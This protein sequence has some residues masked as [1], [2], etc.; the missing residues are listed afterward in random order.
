[1]HSFYHRFPR[2]SLGWMESTCYALTFPSNQLVCQ[3]LTQNQFI[4]YQCSIG[5]LHLC[6]ALTYN[7]QDAKVLCFF[8]GN[9]IYNNNHHCLIV[10]DVMI[11]DK[12]SS[13]VYIAI[14]YQT[15]PFFLKKSHIQ[16]LTW[17]HVWLE[18][19]QAHG[20]QFNQYTQEKIFLLCR[21]NTNIYIY[22]LVLCVAANRVYCPN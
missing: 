13:I 12:R 7:V 22:I 10:Y 3:M 15:P 8:S 18:L 19:P 14:D 1:M 9:R 11:K 4:I 21:L 2:R 17:A 6:T 5:D 16:M 20:S